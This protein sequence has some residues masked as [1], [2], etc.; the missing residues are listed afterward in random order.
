[1]IGFPIVDK[2]LQ[3]VEKDKHVI[4][5]NSHGDMIAGDS[6]ENILTNTCCTHRRC[7]RQAYFIYSNIVKEVM[8]FEG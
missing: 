6:A 4:I 8:P 5:I 7:S 2:Y 3:N 1:M